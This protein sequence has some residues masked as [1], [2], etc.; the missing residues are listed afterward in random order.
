MNC[1]AYQPCAAG[2]ELTDMTSSAPG[3]CRACPEGKYKDASMSSWDS[4]CRALESCGTGTYRAA[5]SA[6]SGGSCVPCAVDTYK[7]NQGSWYSTCSP[8]PSNSGTQGATG[9][10]ERTDCKCNTGWRADASAGLNCVNINE[11]IDDVLRHNCH[12]DAECSDTAGSFTCACKTG[13]EGSGVACSPICGDGFRYGSEAC[14]DGNR[15]DA[16][17]CSGA[18][19][20]EA[21]FNCVNG[22]TSTPDVCVCADNYYTRPSSGKCQIFCE[23]GSTC[24]GNGRCDSGYGYCICNRFYIGADC[25]NSVTPMASQTAAIRDNE[26]TTVALDGVAALVFPPGSFSGTVSA[27]Q[28]GSHQLPEE[29]KSAASLNQ[30]GISEAALVSDVIELGPEGATFDPP[31]TLTMQAGSSFTVSAGK[32]VSAF[33]FDKSSVPQAWKEVAGSTYDASS[34]TTTSS[35]THFSAYAI[36]QFIPPA[37]PPP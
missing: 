12:A 18:C 31:V 33:V 1:I 3:Y 29:M 2:Y 25:G 14:D 24:K 4:V 6:T 22:S 32:S 15:N 17:G 34:K 16:D 10:D 37:S 21:S 7:D 35:L 20:V 27:D 28:Y 13:F 36:L 11:C 30:G 23:A 26:T 19:Q 8:C 9:S 5:A